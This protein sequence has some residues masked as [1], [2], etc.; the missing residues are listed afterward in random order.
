[1][2]ISSIVVSPSLYSGSWVLPYTSDNASIP[3]NLF[4]GI[5]YFPLLQLD[6]YHL[7]IFVR[8]FIF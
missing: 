3:T 1:V 8:F 5:V 7:S 2:H 6:L 4:S